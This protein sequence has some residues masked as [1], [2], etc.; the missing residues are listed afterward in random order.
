MDLYGLFIDLPNAASASEFSAIPL[1]S[2]RRD[3]LAKDAEGAPIFLLHDSS[4]AKY[5]PS[6]NFRHITAQFHN[7]CSVRIETVNLEDQFAVVA[8]DPTAPELHELFVRCFAAALTDLPT[9]AGTGELGA[10]IQKLLDL[11]RAMTHPGGKEVAG[12]WAE[13]FVI[14]KSN[15]ISQ[16]MTAWHAD[17]FDKFDFSWNRGCLEVKASTRDVRVHDFSLEQLSS[18]IGGKGLV[19]SLLLQPL[20][21]GLGIIELAREIENAIVH[22]PELRQKLWNNLTKALGNDFS[23]KLDRRFDTSFAERHIV[24]YSMNDIPAIQ[25][26]SDQRISGVR[27]R[28]DLSTVR[29]SIPGTAIKGLATVFAT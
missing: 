29:S 15:D 10:C 18:P 3:F 5:T 13:L 26:P 1:S 24:L 23:E 8:C 2:S 11:F 14:A 17:P 19:A 22:L 21:G 7:T 25:T 4:T 20:T 6:I 27:F 9:G 16:A 12:L 28:V